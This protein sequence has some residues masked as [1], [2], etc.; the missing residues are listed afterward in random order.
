MT[1]RYQTISLFR[2]EHVLVL[3]E[4]LAKPHESIP[5]VWLSWG[6]CS[7]PP[8]GAR[9]LDTGASNGRA[10][11]AYAN[12]LKKFASDPEACEVQTK[13]MSRAVNYAFDSLGNPYPFKPL[14]NP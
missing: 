8:E 9:G 4:L 11:E 5:D 1:I 3:E 2:F 10:A 6:E 7:C 12:F 13:R 14:G